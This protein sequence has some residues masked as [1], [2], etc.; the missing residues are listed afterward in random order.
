MLDTIWLEARRRI[1]DRVAE[2]DFETWIE[3]LHASGWSNGQ[4]TIE[5]PSVFYRDWLR[6]HFLPLVEE[7]VAEVSG[8]PAAVVVVVNRQLDVPARRPAVS[9]PRRGAAA[10]SGPAPR[11]TFDNFVVGMS[12]QVAFAAAQR[13]VEQPGARFNPLF[14]HGGVG[15]GKTH[16]LHAIRAGMEARGRG[17]VACL[18]AESFVNQMIVALR[19]DRMERF[20]ERFRGI[21]TLVVDDIQ[22]LADKR[23]SQE[24]FCHTFNALHDTRKQIVLASDRPP[25]EMPGIE[26]TLRNRFACGLLADVQPPDPALRLALVRHKGAALGM[27]L[28]V[29]VAGYLAQGW[30]LNVRELEGALSRIELFA[31]VTARS[32]DLALVRE[33]LGPAPGSSA[34]LT[35]DR[36]IDEVCR[37]FEI[38]REEL[39]SARRTARLAVP[40]QLAMYLCRHHTDLPLGRIGAEL[41][42]RDHSTVVHALAAIERRLQKDL[43]L[44]RDV[45]K[46]RARL[47]A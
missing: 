45:T 28:D 19:T 10:P 42:G 9:V 33:V 14:L 39:A 5:A 3:P 41:G 17:R 2:K 23:R 1:R 18:S 35:V 32:I 37:H 36:I 15:L 21:E 7:A 4:L 43:T 29:D 12:N 20:R 46:L 44:R 25:Q 22:F 47:G 31:N 34:A 30:C 13:I 27:T 26:E 8:A 16:L 6:R 38:T 40:R 24:E 11:H